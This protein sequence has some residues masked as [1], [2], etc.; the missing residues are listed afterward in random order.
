MGSET[1]LLRLPT[2][3]W[4]FSGFVLA[5]NIWSLPRRYARGTRVESERTPRWRMHRLCHLRDCSLA[6]DRD[7]SIHGAAMV[8]C[9]RPL[10][11][12]LW[13]WES[14]ESVRRAAV[15][16]SR[17]PHRLQPARL[18]CPWDSPGKHI[19]ASSHSLLQGTFPTQGLNPGL[20]HCMQILSCLSHHGSPRTWDEVLKGA[21][22]CA[23]WGPTREAQRRARVQVAGRAVWQEARSRAGGEGQVGKSQ[24]DFR[25][26]V[27]LCWGPAGSWW[28]HLEPGLLR[29]SQTG[30]RNLCTFVLAFIHL[31]HPPRLHLSYSTTICFSKSCSV[32]AFL[33]SLSCWSWPP[34]LTSVASPLGFLGAPSLSCCC[35][36]SGYTIG[37][38]CSAPSCLSATGS[39]LPVN[40]SV[41]ASEHVT[42]GTKL[43]LSTEE[44]AGTW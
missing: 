13:K 14:G 8:H 7:K 27:W 31:W 22:G 9:P 5:L 16:D 24:V 41:S 35:V 37:F 42:M 33:G 3:L 10:N 2:N 29:F 12:S 36:P 23:E 44:R 1:S 17:W 40:L 15:S 26:D 30:R 38:A 43:S 25:L 32:P 19:G 28:H 34:A 21:P 18:L 11:S 6:A 39:H 20:P 4:T